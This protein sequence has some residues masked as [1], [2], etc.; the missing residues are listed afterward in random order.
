[1]TG[2]R[3]TLPVEFHLLCAFAPL[4]EKSRSRFLAKSP[5]GKSRIAKPACAATFLSMTTVRAIYENGVFRPLEPVDLPNGREVLVTPAQSLPLPP[6]DSAEMA[7][8]HDILGRRYRTG[9]HDVAEHHNEH[10]P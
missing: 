3:I 8:I 4:R 6:T 9:E 1:V 10:Q 2:S 7:A 5:R